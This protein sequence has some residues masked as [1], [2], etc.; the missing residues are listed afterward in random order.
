MSDLDLETSNRIDA[1]ITTVLLNNGTM[2]GFN[3]SLPTAMGEYNVGNIGDDYAGLAQDLGGIGIKITD[4]NEIGGA[5]T[6]ARQ[7]NF[8]KGKSVLLDIK[9][10]QWL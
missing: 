8:V 9:T 2:G 5:L 4:P 1:P 6:K 7:V 3:R 10:Q